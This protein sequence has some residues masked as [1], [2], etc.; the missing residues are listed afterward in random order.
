[1]LMPRPTTTPFVPRTTDVLN[2]VPDVRGKTCT[3][4]RPVQHLSKKNCLTVPNNNINN[5]AL[6]T[7]T[8]RA[9]PRSP[10]LSA[11]TAL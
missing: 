6:I 9:S 5:A 8:A 4:H 7:I 11:L 3:P 1:L 2:I 10:S